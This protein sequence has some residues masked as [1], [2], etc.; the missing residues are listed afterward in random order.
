MQTCRFFFHRNRTKYIISITLFYIFR[1]VTVE[2]EYSQKCRHKG[3]A[4]NTELGLSKNRCATGQRCIGEVGNE[5]RYCKTYSAQHTHRCKGTPVA[6]FRQAHKTAFYSHPREREYSHEL[7]HYK[8]CHNRQ[9][10]T[11]EEC[12]NSHSGKILLRISLLLPHL[13]HLDY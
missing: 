5:D 8:A 12:S 1:Q 4:Q 6:P 2:Q 3:T 10:H 7:A 13:R 9:P 11:C